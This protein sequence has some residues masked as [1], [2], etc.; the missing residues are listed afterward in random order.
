MIRRP[1]RSTRTDTL[2]PY[3]TLFRS[4]ELRDLR[5]GEGEVDELHRGSLA[6]CGGAVDVLLGRADDALA[7]DLEE[8]RLLDA[9]E[10][11]Q[12]GLAALRIVDL[13]HHRGDQLA[14]LR[15]QRVVSTQLVLDLLLA[16]FLDEIGRA[17]V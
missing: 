9:A 2:F 5:V 3:T 12:E 17:H 13:E 16:T 15:N 11:R 6:V 8:C 1:P 4:L 10:L 7:I 14:A